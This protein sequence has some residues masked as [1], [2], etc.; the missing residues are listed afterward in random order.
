MLS[1][2]PR[3]TLTPLSC[4]PIFLRAQYLYI[5]TLTHELREQSLTIGGV[6]LVNFGGGPPI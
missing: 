3:A 5:R 6:R 1:V 4:S 2:A